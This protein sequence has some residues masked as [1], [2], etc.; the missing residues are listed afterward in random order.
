M[1]GTD[2][3]VYHGFTEFFLNGVWIKATP[4]FNIE[5]CR[6][7]NV[8]PLEFN[9]REDCVFQ[10]FNLEAKQFMQYLA[11]H[12][13]YADIPVDRIVAAWEETYGRDRVRAWIADHE[14]KKAA[15]RN[16]FEETV[17]KT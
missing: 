9:G 11:F 1:L 8:P 7:H 2:V 14:N 3:F 16:F 12:G 4:T 6:K 13:S 17:L 5:L 15:T 10:A